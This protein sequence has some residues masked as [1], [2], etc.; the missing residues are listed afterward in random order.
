[1][2]KLL[3]IIS[4]AL[5][6]TL[7][8]ISPVYAAS[9][10]AQTFPGNDSNPMDYTPPEGC[11]HYEIPNS[12]NEGTYTATFNELGEVDPEGLY[13]FTVVVG[14]EEG[15]SYTKILSWN[16]NFPIYGVIVKGGNAFNLYQYGTN[17]REDTNLVAP[18]NPSG[19]PA[20]VSHVSIVI[21]PDEFPPVPPCPPCPP[22][23]DQP[24]SICYGT[25]FLSIFIIFI[26]VFFL[27]GIL[28]GS[29]FLC[30]KKDCSDKNDKNKKEDYHDI[31]RNFK[32]EYLN[33]GG[34]FKDEYNN[35]SRNNKY[36]NYR[37]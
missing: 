26:I 11:I 21:C 9:V 22:C 3:S 2:K 27:L 36:D 15:E 8:I 28:F 23:S 37:N 17:V 24:D 5:V 6:L 19:N 25:L 10:P 20:D 29:V 4:I 32:D 14:S 1:M 35:N 31:D 12:G 34:N 33:N 7:N 13:T 30:Q 18:V 16:S